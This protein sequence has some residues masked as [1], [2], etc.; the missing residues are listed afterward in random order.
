MI[1][2]PE[3]LLVCQNTQISKQNQG[4]NS[5]LALW[6]IPISQRFLEDEGFLCYQISCWLW[7]WCVKCDPSFPTSLTLSFLLHLSPSLQEARSKLL[8]NDF[9]V[10]VFELKELKCRS[11]TCLNTFSIALEIHECVNKLISCQETDVNVNACGFTVCAVPKV[12]LPLNVRWRSCA[13]IFDIHQGVCTKCY[14]LHNPIT[15]HH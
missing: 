11:S 3:S 13:V 4:S 12:C 7:F 5:D 6:V 9:T 14:V 1:I 2:T 15:F 8:L 10:L